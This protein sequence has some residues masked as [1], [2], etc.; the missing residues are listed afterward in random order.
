MCKIY[1][2]T[3]QTPKHKVHKF[4]RCFIVY[5][6]EELCLESWCCF[7]SKAKQVEKICRECA[8]TLIFH[9]NINGASC[10]VVGKKASL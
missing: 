5:G 10:T 7:V 9:L 2:T 4:L 1:F 6:S 3:F 8:V